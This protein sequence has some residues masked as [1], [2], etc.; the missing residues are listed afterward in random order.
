MTKRLNASTLAELFP[1]VE[2]PAYAL[3]ARK[4]GIVHLGMGA[5]ARSHQM[6]VF[7]TL[8]SAGH[9]DCAVSA[10]TMRNT[11]LAEALRAQDGLFSLHAGSLTPRVVG[12]IVRCATAATDPNKVVEAIASPGTRCITLTI[13][14][15]GYSEHGAGSAPAL[16][17][18]GLVQRHLRGLSPLTVMSCDNLP[19]NGQVAKEA[20]LRAV[21]AR[22]ASLAWIA[23]QVRWPSSM[24]D[25]ITPAATAALMEQS[26][27]LL[28]LRDDA[29]LKC[30]AFSQWVLEDRLTEEAPP[31]GNAGVQLV[32][33]VA[34]W[35]TLKLR[36]LNGAHST[37]AYLGLRSGLRFVSEAIRSPEISQVLEELWD[38]LASTLGIG[39]GVDPDHYR[40]LLRRRFADSSV[41]HQ[42]AQIAQD[43]SA[44]LP[45]RL[46][47]PWTERATK[48]L[49]SPAIAAAVQAWRDFI[50][51]R[52]Q[53]DPVSLRD[54]RREALSAAVLGTDSWPELL[55]L[56]GVQD[57][58]R[59]LLQAELA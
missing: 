15:K 3:S 57:A 44:K 41:P 42:L 35:E 56:L 16:I 32:G 21:Q 4:P 26:S 49:K 9:R 17:A 6:P 33:D 12:T 8:L 48:G 36:M 2:R 24:V 51:D 1:A 45:Q 13:T 23:D 11:A 37:L 14:E 54:P 25:R 19:H 59:P 52:V 29:A 55:H 22:D 50:V 58:V 38:E 27:A 40:A 28:G 31:F 43:G 53:S 10:F 5:F 39:S 20:V 18:A 30:E 7:D 34:A 47:A 46:I